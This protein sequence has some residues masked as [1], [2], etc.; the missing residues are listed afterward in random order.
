[1]KGIR[2]RR[3]SVQLMV[4]FIS[5]VL[6][7]G[8]TL[9]VTQYRENT[10]QQETAVAKRFAITNKAISAKVSDIFR[11]AELAVELIS[12]GAV[13]NAPTLEDRLGYRRRL[14]NY[15]DDN[16]SLASVFV[17]YPDGD[18]MLVRRIDDQ[19]TR[20]RFAAPEG[21]SYL[22]QSIDRDPDRAARGLFTFYNARWR[23]VE[24]R[25]ALDYAVYD[26]RKRPWFRRTYRSGGQIKTRP[27]IFFTTREVG[28]TLARGNRGEAVAGI[29]ITLASMSDWLASL[30]P[31]ADSDIALVDADGRLIAH[32]DPERVAG[33]DPDDPGQ[34]RI[35][36]LEMPENRVLRSLTEHAA[37]RGE[38]VT[39]FSV[40]GTDYRGLVVPVPVSGGQTYHMLMA[41]SDDVLFAEADAAARKTALFVAVILLLSVGITVLMSRRIAEP[42]VRLAEDVG[43][44]RRFDFTHSD[45][46]PSR[47]VEID[48]LA[49]AVGRM[50]ET[51]RKFLDISSVIAGEPD[52]DLLL[53]RILDEIIGTTDAEA[54]VLYLTDDEGALLVP[55]AQRLDG[56]RELLLDI[57]TIDITDAASL[58]VQ[59]VR[60]EHPVSADASLAELKHC[61]IVGIEGLVG[62][63]VRAMLAVP[64]FNRAGDL[65][66]VLLL[67][68]DE[69]ID[70][71]LIGFAEALS[72]SVAIS[73]EARRLIAAQRRLFESFLQLIAGAIDTKSPYTG[74]HCERVPELTKMLATAAE[75]TE[76]GPYAN[77]KLTS[78]DWEAVHVAA[79]LHDCGK[80]TS[81]EFVVDKATKLETIYDR[82]HEIRMRFE[83]MKREAEIRYLRLVLEDG[84]SLERREKLAKALAQFDDDFAFVAECNLGGEA[85]SDEAVARLEAISR[86][87]WTRTLDDR[88][89]VSH[90]ERVRMEAN[91]ARELPAEE[92][93]LADKPEHRF[94]RKESDRITPDNPWGFRIDVP[95][96]LYDRGELH[97]LSV[98]RGTL[99]EEDRYKINEH[100]V[101]TIKMLDALPF[102][103]HL[104]EVPELAGGHHEKM[105]GTGYPKRLSKHQMSPVARMMAIADIFEALTAVDRPYKKGKTLSEALRIMCF[106]CRDQH[107]DPELFD[108]FLRS[109]VHLEYA[110]KFLRPEQVDEV[111]VDAL[112]A[113][114]RPAS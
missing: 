27:Y 14:G 33:P 72:G 23:E 79:W 15:L 74:G 80:V 37:G 3:I 53:V 30:A 48:Q 47:I 101:Q 64:L 112:R 29:D 17:G 54:G 50:K 35:T 18:F 82:I 31:T 49:D 6:G 25:D 70:P 39:G 76:S 61:G 92:P 102:P 19:P 86:Q 28:T 63:P 108:L 51:I 68:E 43:S 1:V 9:G 56:R 8:L 87:T 94:E 71:A 109:G 22:V 16:P 104:R 84:D 11:P 52:F 110:R 59:A 97:N 113:I 93:L 103:R 45:L 100:I 26:P 88:L 106:M 38:E 7:V 105:D 62:S 66:G 58:A 5:L 10:R 107:V 73:V 55:Q 95:E 91:P 32:A 13:M 83:V 20:E 2:G 65:V 36:T 81:P 78:D 42:L 44:I 75:R 89:G 4:V 114:Y 99:T 111:D 57:G 41:V 40:D 46:P 24:R 69:V 77:F 96:L 21:A 90:E 34:L 12:R 60:G 85:M 67:L 98:R